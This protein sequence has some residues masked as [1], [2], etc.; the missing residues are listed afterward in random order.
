VINIATNNNIK[1]VI[2]FQHLTIILPFIDNFVCYF[3]EG[4]IR[5]MLEP[6]LR[7]E[8]NA[9]KNDAGIAFFIQGPPL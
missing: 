4:M 2:I 3:C 1:E 6:H 8:A 7:N 5:G 9:T